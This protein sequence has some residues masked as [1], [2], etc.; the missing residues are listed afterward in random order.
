MRSVRNESCLVP[1]PYWMALVGN[2]RACKLGAAAFLA[3]LLLPAP[4][5]AQTWDP[6]QA[7]LDDLV[8]AR[9][10]ATK[11]PSWQIDQAEA[12]RRFAEVDLKPVDW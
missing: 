6:Q 1:S 10:L 11:C 12:Q 5:G 4:A 2:P 8:A 9:M 3:V 7:A